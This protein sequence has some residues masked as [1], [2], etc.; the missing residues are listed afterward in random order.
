[1]DIKSDGGVVRTKL[2]IK[3]DRRHFDYLINDLNKLRPE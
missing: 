3:K 2:C 1:M